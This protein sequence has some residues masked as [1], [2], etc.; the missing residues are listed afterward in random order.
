ML[1]D[2]ETSTSR[3]LEPEPAPKPVRS[4]PGRGRGLRAQRALAFGGALGLVLVY[5]LRGGSYDAVVFQEH[6]LVIW[7]IVA[8]ALAL[9]LLPRSRP[10]VAALVLVGALA[11]YALWTG[12]S[13]IW[14]Q[15]SERSTQELARTLD[16]TGL[17]ALVTL[18]LDRRTWRAG[19]AG[20]G[21]GAMVVCALAVGSRLA[22]SVFPVDYVDTT[23]HIDRL[24]YPFGYWNSVAAW[25]AMSV[26]IGLAW[27]AHDSSRLR[28]AVALGLVPVAGVTLYLTY[29]RAGVAGAG[30]A[31][32]AVLALSR[33]RLTAS[34]HALI[35]G[36]GTAAAVLAVRGAPE[37]AHATGT[38][39]AGSVFVALLVAA[40]AGAAVAV[41]SQVLDVD[42]RRVPRRL[43]R[44]LAGICVLL[45][46]VAAAA[47]GPRLISKGWD[48]FTR[49]TVVNAS[50]PTARLANLSGSRYPLWKVTLKAYDKHPLDGT[51]A[52]TFEFWWDR[53]ATNPEFVRDSH[54]LWLQNM[55]ELGTPGLLLIIAVAVSGLVLAG[56]VRYRAR[57]P[58]S[59]GVST[60]FLAAYIVFLMHASVDWMWQS[61]AVTVLALAGVAA[62]GARG[63][64]RPLRLSWPVRGAAVALAACGGLIQ[65]PGLL[66]TGSVRR[67]Q[68]AERAGNSRSALAW[69]K[70]AVNA[71]PW[72]AAAYE[73]R[74][75]VLEASGQLDP[76]ASDLRH[77]IQ[78]EP[79][80]FR[81]WL[82]LA[83][84]DTERGALAQAV[85]DYT[86]A[87]ELRPLARVFALAPYFSGTPL[88]PTLNFGRGP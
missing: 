57:R 83:R 1:T 21:F 26:A 53:H 50:D 77:A 73:Q 36:A 82:V 78:H 61:T 85:R 55:A 46:L 40:L 58:V 42:A 44:P 52:G 81:H 80:N 68:A 23:F 35:A 54:N 39:G 22:P 43:F 13:L 47:V 2:G 62:V 70:A 30:L 66:S 59:A 29:S 69:A 11:A 3:L 49:T 74:G 19:A 5:A 33:N 75:L 20:L 4:S 31:V 25:A 8:I 38:A 12:L 88:V 72:S 9:G 84:I 37:V 79:T 15:S 41:L 14:T 76:A 60:A 17:V 16:Y 65:L 51:G 7:W 67:S 45:A 6:G 64:F 18:A 71:E 63:A 34:L 27:S 48:S 10:P 32:I 24:S 87:H 86:R 28:R 56:G